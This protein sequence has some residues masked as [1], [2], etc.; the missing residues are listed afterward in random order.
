MNTII[1][2]LHPIMIPIALFLQGPEY[3]SVP[4]IRLTPGGLATLVLIALLIGVFLGVSFSR[5]RIIT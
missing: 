2:T 1:A 4:V 3:R 5:P